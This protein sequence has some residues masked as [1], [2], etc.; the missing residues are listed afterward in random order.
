MSSV[1]ILSKFDKLEIGHSIFKFQISSF[2]FKKFMKS[3]EI[4][5][6]IYFRYVKGKYRFGSANIYS[7]RVGCFFPMV[8][9]LWSSSLYC[10]HLGFGG[11]DHWEADPTL[12]ISKYLRPGYANGKVKFSLTDKKNSLTRSGSVQ[13]DKR[14]LIVMFLLVF[15]KF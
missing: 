8:H 10:P 7:E 15:R 2:L 11:N 6:M 13:S 14:K 5:N 4:V 1:S 3:M 9:S 12:L